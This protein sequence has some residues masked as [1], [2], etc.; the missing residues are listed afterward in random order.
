MEALA[1]A[2]EGSGKP[3]VSTSG[4]A[5]LAPGRT[6]TEDEAP[7]PDSAAALRAASEATVLA[8]AARDVR[9][10]VVRLRKLIPGLKRLSIESSDP[11]HYA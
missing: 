7:A 5:L 11:I 3:F 9:T 8:A 6:C 10:S 4:T 2:L 1:A